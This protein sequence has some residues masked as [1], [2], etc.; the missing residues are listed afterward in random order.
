MATSPDLPS[1]IPPDQPDPED[2][3]DLPVEPDD[4]LSP[5]A[6]AGRLPAAGALPPG[7]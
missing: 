6:Y 5:P 4:G 3:A 2:P 1:P 7:P